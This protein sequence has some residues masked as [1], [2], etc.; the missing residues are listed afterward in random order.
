MNETLIILKKLSVLLTLLAGLLANEPGTELINE[1][2]FGV[3]GK[4]IVETTTV[5]ETTLKKILNGTSLAVQIGTCN[6]TADQINPTISLSN[7]KLTQNEYQ[8]VKTQYINRI[9]NRTSNSCATDISSCHFDNQ[10][11]FHLWM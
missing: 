5:R 4:N 7:S 11:D 1:P 2:I 3:A 10:I 8:Q 9:K 6:L